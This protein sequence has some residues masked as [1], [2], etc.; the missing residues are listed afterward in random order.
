MYIKKYLIVSYIVSSLFIL[1]LFY[2]DK[3]FNYIN[4][5]LY[6][7]NYLFYIE[8]PKI[9]LNEFIYPIDSILNNVDYN[10]ELLKSSKV[11]KNLLYIAGHSG[12]ARNSYFDNLI[13]LEKGD[14]I[15]LNKFIFVVEKIY[16]IQKDGNFLSY[17]N[18]EGNTLFL[19]TCS[20]KYIDKQLII[21]AK[22][23]N[24]I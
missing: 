19:I 23:I 2:N 9:N 5:Y 22:L 16:F 4:N 1:Y 13:Y 6:K 20:L 7:D 24:D 18:K 8:I 17:Y 10:I 11:D 3:I 12:S 21:K 14:L 15:Y